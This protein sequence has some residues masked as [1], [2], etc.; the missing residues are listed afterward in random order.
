[1]V[2]C[3]L[4]ILIVKHQ[5]I[6]VFCIVSIFRTSKPP[7]NITDSEILKLRPL[8]HIY[9]APESK[10]WSRSVVSTI[11]FF[12]RHAR[13]FY[14]NL[15]PKAVRQLGFILDNVL[16]PQSVPLRTLHTVCSPLT[17]V[18]LIVVTDDF[19]DSNPQKFRMHLQSAPD[20]ALLFPQTHFKT[21]S[22]QV[23]IQNL[24]TYLSF[25]AKLEYG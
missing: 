23:S 14:I 18:M 2:Q 5:W 13:I 10:C 8:L 3:S 21:F 25:L 17:F 16:L 7:V 24:M 1:M 4:H 6:A 22:F 15:S 9:S 12:D 19:I 11:S 20:F